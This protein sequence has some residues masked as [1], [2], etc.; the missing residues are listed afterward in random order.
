M[1]KVAVS[2][3]RSIGLVGVGWAAPQLLTGPDVSDW[4]ATLKAWIGAASREAIRPEAG[5][6]LTTAASLQIAQL[7][8]A[9]QALTATVAHGQHSSGRGTLTLVVAAGVVGAVLWRGFS[10]WGWVTAEQLRE[11]VA[12]LRTSLGALIDQVKTDLGERIFGVQEA[13]EATQATVARVGESIDEL[14]LDVQAKFSDME[15]KMDDVELHSKRAAS[16]VE[17]LLELVASSSTLT[18][19]AN[20]DALSRLRTFTGPRAAAAELPAPAGCSPSGMLEHR[21]SPPL[22]LAPHAL[23]YQQA[24][25]SF[26]RAVLT[27]PL[28]N[29]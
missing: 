25:P 10:S 17:I 13:V 16:G 4:T 5:A 15:R 23:P 6:A 18:A 21:A 9:V 11:H 3:T 22:P 28:T 20:S 7:S 26:M 24:A 29:P 14:R 19:G 27:Q 8:T 12:G 2:L 1:A